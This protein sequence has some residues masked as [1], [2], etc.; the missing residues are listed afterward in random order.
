MHDIYQDGRG[1]VLKM[2]NEN[3]HSTTGKHVDLVLVI[4][5]EKCDLLVC[6]F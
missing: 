5:L 2:A 3:L 6:S 4:N 1:S